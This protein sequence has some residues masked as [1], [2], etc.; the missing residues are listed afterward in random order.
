MA[1][2]TNDEIQY[3]NARLTREQWGAKL[4]EG[5][6]PAAVADTA[7]FPT[8]DTADFPTADTAAP[9]TAPEVTPGA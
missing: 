2:L 4:N 8:A 9:L 7:D 3:E 6:A 5:L 1:D